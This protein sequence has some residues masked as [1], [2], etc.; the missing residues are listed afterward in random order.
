MI[1]LL[2]L[3][4]VGHICMVFGALAALLSVSN[5]RYLCWV[6]VMGN[7]MEYA[8]YY[9]YAYYGVLDSHWELFY[10]GIA[11]IDFSMLSLMTYCYHRDYILVYPLIFLMVCVNAIIAP[12][13]ILIES[14]YIWSISEDALHALNFALLLILFGRSDGTLR[15]LDNVYTTSMGKSMVRVFRL[16]HSLLQLGMRSKNTEMAEK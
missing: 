1:E 2:A 15:L 8:I 7:V 11:L 10:L 16:S 6:F 13:W 9:I 4:E 3:I 5:K 14:D 12:L